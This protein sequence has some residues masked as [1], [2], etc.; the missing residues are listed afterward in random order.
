MLAHE[1]H[2]HMTR[3]WLLFYLFLFIFRNLG[4]LSNINVHCNFKNWKIGQITHFYVDLRKIWFLHF[5]LKFLY[6]KRLLLLCFFIFGKLTSLCRTIAQSLVLGQSLWQL[7]L[8]ASC[9]SA[10]EAAVD[11]CRFTLVDW[12]S[13]CFALLLAICPSIDQV[14]T[15]QLWSSFLTI[16]RCF[17]CHDNKHTK[18]Q[19]SGT[20]C[21]EFVPRIGV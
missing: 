16:H 13:S 6:Q 7:F 12:C 2:P 11:R 10:A 17:A 1:A 4:K 15:F 20:R 5:L 14:A 8:S 21:S 9:P 18:P 19:A 3:L